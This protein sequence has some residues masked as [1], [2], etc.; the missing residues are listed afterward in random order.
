MDSPSA[1]SPTSGSMSRPPATHDR[2]ELSPSGERAVTDTVR[3]TVLRIT[4]ENKENDYRVVK[5]LPE[6]AVDRSSIR[7]VSPGV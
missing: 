4:F 3:G 6:R 7:S 1:I 5:L 2:L